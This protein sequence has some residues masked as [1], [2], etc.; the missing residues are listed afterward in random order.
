MTTIKP[1]TRCECRDGSGH[2]AQH[3]E[4]PDLEQR[5]CPNDAVRLVT[6]PD[7]WDPENG[8]YSLELTLDG[9]PNGITLPMCAACATYH[10]SKAGAR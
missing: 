4:L 8:D 5:Q 3:V 9:V 10:E 6:V 1:S 2:R 7:Y